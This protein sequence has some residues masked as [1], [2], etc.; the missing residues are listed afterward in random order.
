MSVHVA[1]ISW[2]RQEQ[3]FLDNRY[4]R[5]HEWRFD[6]GSVVRASSAPTS[7]PVPFSDATA[8]DPE[9]AFVA[10]LSS[11]HM[12]WFLSIA[13]KRGFVVD[14]YLDEAEGIL[15]MGADGRVSITRVHLRPRVRIVGVRRPDHSQF[16][17]LHH[18]AH[19]RCFIANSVKTDVRCEAVLET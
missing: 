6:G 18:E 11:Y 3:V 10:T 17:A 7:V 1:T 19:D 14:S 4:S 16:E 8:I 9:E 15:E 2:T 12:L 13:A 5:S